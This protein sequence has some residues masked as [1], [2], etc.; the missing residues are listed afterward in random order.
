MKINGIE[1]NQTTNRRKTVNGF[2]KVA[3]SGMSLTMATFYNP[4]TKESFTKRVWDIDDDRLLLEDDL[5][6]LRNL[7]ID[8][9]AVIAWK[10]HNGNFVVGDSV[11]VVKGRKISKGTKLKV[12]WMGERLTY[13][14]QQLRKSGCRWANET[15]MIAGCYNENGE[16][17]WIKTEYLKYLAA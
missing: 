14:A 6:E 10:H 5:Q 12:F 2:F 3:E 8:E 11:E 4:D 9:E 13:K 7:P 15:E 1:L 17:V 16:K